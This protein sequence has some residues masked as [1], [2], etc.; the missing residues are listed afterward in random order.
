MQ[1]MFH[2]IYIVVLTVLGK[3][4][5]QCVQKNLRIPTICT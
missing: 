4:Y 1:L 3:V 2:Y 5:K